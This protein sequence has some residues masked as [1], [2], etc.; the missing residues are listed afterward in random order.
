[1]FWIAAFALLFDGYYLI[2]FGQNKNTGIDW[3]IVNDTVMGGRSD[4]EASLTENSLIFTGRVSLENNGGFASIRSPYADFDLSPYKTVKIRCRGKGQK[5]ALSFNR[6][7]EWYRPNYK[8]V[9]QPTEEWQE[10]EFQLA[11]FVEYSVGRQTGNTLSPEAQE[12]IIRMTFI[13]M[14]KAA[15]SFEFEVDYLRFE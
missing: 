12:N 2:D 15:T 13:T 3:R 10:F 1:M 8:A 7:R 9:F 4:S 5:M 11:D 6:Y 14:S